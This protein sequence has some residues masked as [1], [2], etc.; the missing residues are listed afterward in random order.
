MCILV[1]M[2]AIPPP[3]PHPTLLHEKMK[4]EGMY[5]VHNS[6]IIQTQECLPHFSEHVEGPF[7]IVMSL[8]VMQSQHV[9]SQGYIILTIYN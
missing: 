1:F 5:S 6:W 9:I 3:T 4:V 2:S 8:Y 7:F